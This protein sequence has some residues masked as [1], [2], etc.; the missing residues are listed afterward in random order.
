MRLRVISPEPSF[1]QVQPRDT[2]RGKVQV[3]SSM[4][5]KPRLHLRVVVCP[6]VVL[7]QVEGHPMRRVSASG[8]QE[9]QKLL[10]AV[11]RVTGAD[12]G[13]VEHIEH[14]EQT[15]GPKVGAYIGGSWR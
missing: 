3:E 2:R 1:D 4:L 13:A 7:N 11:P 12:H 6:V 15:S 10:V 9:L 14:R 8:A 5:L